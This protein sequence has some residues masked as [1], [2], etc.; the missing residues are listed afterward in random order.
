MGLI[1]LANQSMEGAAAHMLAQG[2]TAAWHQTLGPTG[3][4]LRYVI[5]EEN[6][7]GDPVRSLIRENKVGMVNSYIDKQI[8][9]MGKMHGADPTTGKRF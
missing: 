7:N 8:A 6:N 1:H 2:L 5:T 4:F 3:P 9:R